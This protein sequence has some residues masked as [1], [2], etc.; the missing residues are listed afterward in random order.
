MVLGW[1]RGSLILKLG[2]KRVGQVFC[3]HVRLL[4]SCFVVVVEL[5]RIPPFNLVA[6]VSTVE[7]VVK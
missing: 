3:E 4:V 7:W 5:K 2:H 6:R 1:V